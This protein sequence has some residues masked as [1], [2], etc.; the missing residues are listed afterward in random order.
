MCVYFIITLLTGLQNSQTDV[1][2][3]FIAGVEFQPMQWISSEPSY[4][5]RQAIPTHEDVSARG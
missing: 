2:E 5:L 1:E 3:Y 4:H